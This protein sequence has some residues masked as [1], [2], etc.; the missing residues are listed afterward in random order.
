MTGSY[1][2][3]CK[4]RK[5]VFTDG[6]ANNNFWCETRNVVCMALVKPIVLGAVFKEC[7]LSLL[8]EKTIHSARA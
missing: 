7:L 6:E 1:F 4:G 8:P 3:L 5:G 2:I